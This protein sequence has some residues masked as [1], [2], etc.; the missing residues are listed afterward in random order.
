MPP[1]HKANQRAAL[2]RASLRKPILHK[3]SPH[4]D[5]IAST[6]QDREPC[7]RCGVRADV[8]AQF[9]CKQHHSH[10]AVKERF[11]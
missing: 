1:K 2:I 5:D 8:H 6:V 3:V 11:Y 7:G 4:R 10:I 9:G